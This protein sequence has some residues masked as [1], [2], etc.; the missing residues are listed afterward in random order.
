M[1]TPVRNEAYW[2]TFNKNASTWLR[3]RPRIVQCLVLLGHTQAR[4]NEV[5]DSIN[6]IWLRGSPINLSFPTPQEAI[7]RDSAIAE[8]SQLFPEVFTNFTPNGPEEAKFLNEKIGH[9]LVCVV[10]EQARNRRNRAAKR[11][12][13]QA[14]SSDNKVNNEEDTMEVDD[15]IE[16][17]SEEE[18]MGTTT[19]PAKPIGTIQIWSTATATIITTVDVVDV[20]APGTYSPSIDSLRNAVRSALPPSATSAAA[21]VDFSFVAILSSDLQSSEVGLNIPIA[22]QQ[23]LAIEYSDWVGSRKK[24]KPWYLW[25]VVHDGPNGHPDTLTACIKSDVRRGWAEATYVKLPL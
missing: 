24:A 25:A 14:G 11:N 12:D 4:A 17:D 22:T 23:Q 2:A 1:P 7:R 10:N 13:P 20:L 15:G 5:L 21:N 8:V 19:S 16:D 6:T 18:E 3:S 9:A